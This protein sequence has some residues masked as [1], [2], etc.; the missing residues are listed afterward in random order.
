MVTVGQR[1]QVTKYYH[2]LTRICHFTCQLWPTFE[3]KKHKAIK[4]T[5]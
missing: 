5:G 4:I 2:S 3:N 1:E